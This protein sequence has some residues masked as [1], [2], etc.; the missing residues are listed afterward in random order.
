[1][2]LVALAML[3]VAG[4]APTFAQ[5]DSDDDGFSDVVESY[6]GTDPLDN[7]PDDDADDAWPLDISMSGDISVTGDVFHYV[8]EVGMTDS[9]PEWTPEV[10]RLDLNTSGD[11]TVTGD[12]FLYVGSI[13]QTCT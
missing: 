7:C 13:G 3:G 2:V 8:G 11:I 1:M 10:Q 5:A 4:A 9:Q 12:I 6:L